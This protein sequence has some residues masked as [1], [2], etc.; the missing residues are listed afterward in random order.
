MKRNLFIKILC[1]IVIISF[2][3][4]SVLIPSRA[5]AQWIVYDPTNHAQ[6]IINTGLLTT[7]VAQGTV[8]EV[9]ESI[10]NGLAWMFAKLI[11]QQLTTSVVNWINS[12]FDGA[13]SFVQNPGSFFL[14]VADQATGAFISGKLETLC[15]PFSI[16]LRIA[17][18]FKYH[19]KVNAEYTC[20]LGTIIQNSKNAIKNASIN[21]FTAGDFR[22]GGW[23]A[24]ISMTTEPQNNIYSSYLQADMGITLDVAGLHLGKKQQLIQGAGI[25][26]KEVCVTNPITVKSESTQAPFYSSS[27]LGGSTSQ[28][29]SLLGS[30]NS[31]VGQ[32][33]QTA[34]ANAG[35][36]T[37][38]IETPG[39]VISNFLKKHLDAPTDQLNLADS[40]NEIVGALFTQ[41]VS[42]ILTKGLGA[43]SGN[44]PSDSN[45]YINQIRN[46]VGG[47]SQQVNSIGRNLINQVDGALKPALEYQANKDASLALF[48]TV[49]GDYETAKAC[50]AQKIVTAQSNQGF[51]QQNISRYQAEIAEIDSIIKNQ[52]DPLA[53]KLVEGA[54]EADDRIATL[55]EIKEAAGIAKTLNDLNI[56]SQKFT[57]LIQSGSMIGENEVADSKKEY[58]QTK[59][60]VAKFQQ[61]AK[62]KLQ[63]CKF[64]N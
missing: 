9:R 4:P 21:G 47:T 58:D 27:G 36:K 61:D 3:L 2:I 56:P 26:S 49:R 5:K 59:K 40:I 46:E 19:Q 51:W 18:A 13:P 50:Y 43:V 15:S 54:K 45:S 38:H 33:S 39:S 62:R 14:N 44:G 52:I 7:L 30:N 41:L 24:F 16:D 48:T 29:G 1:S 55:E 60:D 20:T 8:K 6:N 37:C 11:V 64:T 63:E 35:T 10:L 32:F 25:L 23:P 53:A 28:V 34:K 17:L 42:Q 12:G 31:A 57:A 22:Q